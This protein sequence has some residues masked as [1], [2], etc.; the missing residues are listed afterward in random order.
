M[1][2]KLCQC[3]INTVQIIA[4]MKKE[5]NDKNISRWNYVEMKEDKNLSRKI[6]LG[7]NRK[8]MK[9]VERK[10]QGKIMPDEIITDDNM[11]MK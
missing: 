11:R 3:E 6:L 2:T 9:N 10:Y 1:Q 7:Q 5:F 4:T 8:W